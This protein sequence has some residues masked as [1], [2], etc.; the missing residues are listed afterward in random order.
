VAERD[1][2]GRLVGGVG[3]FGVE[4]DEEVVAQPVVL[5]ED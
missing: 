5:G 4:Q 3:V 2:H 1:G